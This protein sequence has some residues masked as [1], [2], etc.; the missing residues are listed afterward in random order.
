MEN[1]RVRKHDAT[2][3]HLKG[4]IYSIITDNKL[5]RSEMYHFKRSFP[6]KYQKVAFFT[7][8]VI[9]FKLHVCICYLKLVKNKRIAWTGS[10]WFKVKPY[11]SSAF[12]R[13]RMHERLKAHSTWID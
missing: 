11:L 10:G 1:K 13:S 8:K 6:E 5:R 12:E 7:I 3:R 2:K 4:F 9:F